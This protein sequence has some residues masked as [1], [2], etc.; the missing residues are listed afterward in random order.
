[1]TAACLMGF[2][3]DKYVASRAQNRDRGYQLDFEVYIERQVIRC[4]STAHR[5]R[6]DGCRDRRIGIWDGWYSGRTEDEWER[7]YPLY[8]RGCFRIEFACR[9]WLNEMLTLGNGCSAAKSC[10]P[11]NQ[12]R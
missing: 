2:D 4:R 11:C 3:A 5:L 10:R 9:R 1:M 6:V 7:V 8:G 12:R